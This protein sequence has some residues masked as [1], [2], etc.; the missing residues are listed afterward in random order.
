MNSTVV[1]GPVE[2][3]GQVSGKCTDDPTVQAA[4]RTW[5]PAPHVP[6]TLNVRVVRESLDFWVSVR[7]RRWKVAP[8]ERHP[9]VP[10]WLYTAELLAYGRVVAVVLGSPSYPG[11]LVEL[12]AP[13]RLRDVC[14]LA[15]GQSTGCTNWCRLYTSTMMNAWS[16]RCLPVTGSIH[17]PSRPKSTCASSPGSQ[18]TPWMTTRC[19]S[20]AWGICA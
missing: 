3:D 6:G 14:R 17:R 7:G 4:A 8:Q 11:D 16:M 13:D 5:L 10:V 12:L 1:V 18:S 9:T 15:D 2:R 19:A 20:T